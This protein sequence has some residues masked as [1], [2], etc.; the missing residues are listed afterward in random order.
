[1]G[2]NINLHVYDE[3]MY[4]DSHTSFKFNNDWNTQNSVVQCT[5]Y[6]EFMILNLVYIITMG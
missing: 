2:F 3:N 1:M 4:M 6:V 5:I